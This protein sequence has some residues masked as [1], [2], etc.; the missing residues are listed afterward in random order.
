MSYFLQLMN[1]FGSSFPCSLKSLNSF[2]TMNMNWIQYSLSV[3]RRHLHSPVMN[4]FIN[5]QPT[6]DWSMQSGFLSMKQNHIRRL[7]VSR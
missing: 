7:T 4:M 3:Q 6:I 5:G 1:H 2:L